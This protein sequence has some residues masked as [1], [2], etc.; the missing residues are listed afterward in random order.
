MDTR[1]IYTFIFNLD[2]GLVTKQDVSKM[3]QDLDVDFDDKTFGKTRPKDFP[4]S[5]PK[6]KKFFENFKHS[7]TQQKNIVVSS[8]WKPILT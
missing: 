4:K 3:K 7:V 1:H 5:F 2:F 6:L 8:F